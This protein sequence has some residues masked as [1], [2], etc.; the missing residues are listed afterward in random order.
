MKKTILTLLFGLCF[1]MLVN[2]Q[3][4]PRKY[5]S[6]PFN[7]QSLKEIGCS[8]DQIKKITDI[9]KAVMEE[10]KKVTADTALSERD[11]KLEQRKLIDKS[12]VQMMEVLTDEQK[13][14]VEEFNNKAKEEK[15]E[16]Q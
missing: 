9:R 6:F 5:T 1:T 13:Q 2:A 15:A 3:D 8:A 7:A 16:N 14:K 11:K 10:R 4:S 12:K